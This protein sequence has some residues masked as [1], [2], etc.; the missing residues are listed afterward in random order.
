MGVLFISVVERRPQ[1]LINLDY[2][3]A[4]KEATVGGGTLL[5][6]LRFLP[7]L[8][9]PSVR[10]DALLHVDSCK[11]K[12]ERICFGGGNDCVERFH[13]YGHTCKVLK[14]RHPNLGDKELV[15]TEILD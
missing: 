2:S 9:Y 11:G 12:L 3:L 4:P 5:G 14:M 8:A 7:R 13:N 6:V 15:D 10:H 1:D